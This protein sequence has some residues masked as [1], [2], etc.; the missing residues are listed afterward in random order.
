MCNDDDRGKKSE[1][2]LFWS[3]INSFSTHGFTLNCNSKSVIFKGGSEMCRPQF[4]HI[5]H[6]SPSINSIKHLWQSHPSLYQSR[7]ERERLREVMK[8][9]WTLV[10]SRRDYFSWQSSLSENEVCGISPAYCF[11]KVSKKNTFSNVFYTCLSTNSMQ[12]GVSK[13]QQ[14]KL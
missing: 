12:A 9:F 7:W 13:C 14:H 6:L 5:N 4:F 2:K 11:C 8:L 3:D 1:G 10:N